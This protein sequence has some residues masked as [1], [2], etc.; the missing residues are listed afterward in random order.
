M[1]SVPHGDV[2][3]DD[4][5]AF[6]GTMRS[7][8]TPEKSEFQLLITGV[9]VEKLT[10]WKRSEI[11]S[12]QDA[13]QA[14]FL[15]LVDIF[16]PQICGCF[17]RKRLFQHPQA[18]SLIDSIPRSSSNAFIGT[19][20]SLVSAPVRDRPPGQGIIGADASRWNVSLRG[21]DILLE[22]QSS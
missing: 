22:Q 20:S 12:H 5:L 18:D 7:L 2:R 8:P 17:L 15:T 10:L 14:T 6:S 16:Y 21:Y 4:R 19:T 9:A 13:L 11:S 1:G 3:L